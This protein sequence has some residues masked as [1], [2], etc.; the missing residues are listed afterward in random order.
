MEPQH[1][2]QIGKFVNIK[3]SRQKMHVSLRLQIENFAS[4]IQFEKKVQIQ[5][6]QYIFF[7]AIT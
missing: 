3:T 7:D 2:I 1:S 5:S 4:T 6:Y